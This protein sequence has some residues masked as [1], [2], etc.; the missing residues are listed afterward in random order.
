MEY[1]KSNNTYNLNSENPINVYRRRRRIF[2]DN[3]VKTSCA[4]CSLLPVKP[5]FLGK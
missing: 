5:I 4:I 1:S 3:P 2:T